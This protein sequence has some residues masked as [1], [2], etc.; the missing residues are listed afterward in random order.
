MALNSG[1]VAA[2][3]LE[4]LTEEVGANNFTNNGAV[5]FVAGK[6]NNGASIQTSGQYLST[7][8]VFGLTSTSD[9]SIS[10]WVNMAAEVAD[11]RDMFNM[12]WTGATGSQIRIVY[13]HNAGTKRLRGYRDPNT[14]FADVVGAIADGT[15]KNVVL[16]WTNTANQL[17]LYVNN[18]TAA[19]GNSTGT[20]SIAVANQ[21][22]LGGSQ[23]YTFTK[24]PIGVMDDCVI[25]NRV[26]SASERTELYNGG[27]GRAYP[28]PNSGGLTLLG[29][30]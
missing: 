27:P 12:A 21:F 20:A 16:T 9:F 14:A 10:F 3:K 15:Y 7:T 13:E 22:T 19:I 23:Q 30:G 5:T 8:S 4:N 18:G 25:W 26:L 24:P 17:F 1:I 11:D 29:V 28:F 6:F 2:Y